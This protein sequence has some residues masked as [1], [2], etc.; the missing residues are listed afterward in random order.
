MEFDDCRWI[1][2]DP[3]PPAPKTP[4]WWVVN[5]ADD[6]V[7]GLIGWKGQWWQYAFVP[8]PGVTLEARCMSDIA[9]F[10]SHQTLT[11]LRP[12]VLVS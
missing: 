12:K 10:C 9:D 5:K 8:E 6:S 4:R 3:A 1:R 11:K 2:F 7:L